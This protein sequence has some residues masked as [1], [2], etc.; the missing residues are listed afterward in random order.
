[1]KAFTYVIKDET[2]IHAR[3]AGLLC[4]LAKEFKSEIIIEK[5]GKRVNAVKLMMLMGLGVKKGD[6]VTVTADGPDEDEASER[7]LR[8]FEEN[9]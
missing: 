9:L 3:P 2:G 4:G 5:D 7:L 1:M 6:S 8:F